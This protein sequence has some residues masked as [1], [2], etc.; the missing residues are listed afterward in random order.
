MRAI[1]SVGG[2]VLAPDLD[3]ERVDAY[4]DCV[5]TL[6][7]AGHEMGLVVGG[8]RVAREYIETGRELGA[9]EMALDQL[10]IGVTRLNARL[11][12]AALG[13]SATPTPPAGYEEAAAAFRQSEIPVMGGLV[14]GQTTDAVSAALAETVDADLLVYATSVS[15]VY[16]ADP[17]EDPNAIHYEELTTS[18]LVDIIGGIEMSAG[19]NAPVGL[20]AAKLIQ[21]S[22]T[23]TIVLDGTDPETVLR[24]IDTGDHDGT[25]VIP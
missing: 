9:N 19:S 17:E 7:E 2:S 5:E 24:A 6:R 3:S 14:P 10:G 20:L 15:G 1:V 23:R 22:E 11:L 25:E 16:S 18:E 4:A 13:E 21:R 12:I 8:G